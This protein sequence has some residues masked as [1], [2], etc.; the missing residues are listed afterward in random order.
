MDKLALNSISA[1]KSRSNRKRVGRGTGSGTGKTAGRGHKGQKARSGGNIRQG[2]EG[3]Q[4]P[5]HRRV[6][7]RGFSNFLFKKEYQ[8]VNIS[9]LDKIESELIDPSVMRENGLVKYALRPIKVLGNGELN[10]KVNVT[11][12]AFSSSATK[13]IEKKGGTVTVQ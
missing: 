12:S 7:K 11:A 5:L 10:K 6:P 9:D 4:M 1:S 8:I 13:K 2:F 3:G